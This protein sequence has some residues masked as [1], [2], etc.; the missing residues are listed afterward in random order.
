[1][2]SNINTVLPLK[3]K[4]FG[5]LTNQL[6]EKSI[7]LEYQEENN[8][9]ERLKRRNERERNRVKYINDEFER[10]AQLLINSD[11][12]SF[13]HEMCLD[14]TKRKS[15]SKVNTLRIAIEY[16]NYLDN[17]LKTNQFNLESD[18][19]YFDFETKTNELTLS[20]DYSITNDIDNNEID[21]LFNEIHLFSS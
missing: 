8:E 18:Q 19:N 11:H 13:Q 10:L 15:L 6:A 1:M 12:E 2:F 9:I 14:S 20:Q 5:D 3:R 21:L 17:I 7:K 4:P 16:I